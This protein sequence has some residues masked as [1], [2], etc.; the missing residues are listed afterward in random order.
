RQ[1]AEANDFDNFALSV[2][3]QITGLMIDRMDKN[4]AIVSKFLDEDEF[5]ALVTEHIA[6]RIYEG[7]KKAG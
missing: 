1:R 3:E 2:K 6:R 5:K 7:L 4:E